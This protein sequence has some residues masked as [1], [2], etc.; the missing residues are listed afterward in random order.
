MA[1]PSSK[2]NVT[3]HAHS[4]QEEK[5]AHRLRLSAHPASSCSSCRG[6]PGPSNGSIT[7]GPKRQQLRASPSEPPSSSA[8]RNRRELPLLD[9]RELTHTRRCWSPAELQIKA[10]GFYLFILLVS[11]DFYCLLPQQI[12][13]HKFDLLSETNHCFL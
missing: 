7:T 1:C 11:T 3:T 9:K 12:H 8:G 6:E 4:K 2:S 10:A 13:P 5:R